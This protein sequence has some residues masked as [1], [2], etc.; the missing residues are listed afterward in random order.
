M[1]VDER[2]QRQNVTF[3][4]KI[5]RRIASLI[6]IE[7]F[8]GLIRQWYIGWQR[9]FSDHLWRAGARSKFSSKRLQE[10]GRVDRD[11]IDALA[12][13]PAGNTWWRRLTKC[14]RPTWKLVERS[15]DLAIQPFEMLIGQIITNEQNRLAR[16]IALKHNRE[17]L[18]GLE[19]LLVIIF[20]QNQRV[21]SIQRTA[22]LK[23][24]GNM[25]ILEWNILIADHDLELAASLTKGPLQAPAQG[26]RHQHAALCQSSNQLVGQLRCSADC[27]NA[28]ADKFD[29]RLA[30]ARI[31]VGLRHLRER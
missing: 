8:I 13:A 26:C 4:A 25:F 16:Q 9:T 15:G 29:Q 17:A 24:L 10:I 28:S 1:G 27:L 31:F 18:L 11:D 21:T 3:A 19:E 23:Q 5:D 6:I 20:G 2:T 30:T 7:Q 22:Q 12:L 14:I